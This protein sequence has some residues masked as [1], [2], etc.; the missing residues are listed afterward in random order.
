MASVIARRLNKVETLSYEPSLGEEFALPGRNI[1]AYGE[2]HL[3]VNMLCC[4]L[5]KGK[6]TFVPVYQS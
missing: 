6:V 3:M 4:R 1:C 2:K 5:V